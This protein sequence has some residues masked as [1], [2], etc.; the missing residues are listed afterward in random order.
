[1]KNFSSEMVLVPFDEEDIKIAKTLICPNCGYAGDIIPVAGEIYP[2]GNI[3]PP[4]FE[5]I[6]CYFE[7]FEHDFKKSD[8]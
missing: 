6:E 2:D 3:N 8:K 1:M 5:C 4:H 7:G